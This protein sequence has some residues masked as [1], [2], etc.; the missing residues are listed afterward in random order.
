MLVLQRFISQGW[1]VSGV[2]AGQLRYWTISDMFWF[3]VK[4]FH[5]DAPSLPIPLVQTQMLSNHLGTIF[6]L[7]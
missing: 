3:M 6:L 1:R 5:V 2:H 4:H 7:D